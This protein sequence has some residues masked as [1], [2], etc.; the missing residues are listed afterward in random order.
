MLEAKIT[1]LNKQHNKVL[2][3]LEKEFKKQ[4]KTLSQLRKD[5]S[6]TE[7]VTIETSDELS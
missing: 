2:I 6:K 4:E 5:Q 1:Q 3:Q 7:G